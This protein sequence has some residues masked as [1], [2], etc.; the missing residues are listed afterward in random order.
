M[1]NA[2]LLLML[3]FF[4]TSCE[5]EVEVNAPYDDIPVVYGLLDA[6][7]SVHYI[8]INKTFLG[9]GNANDMAAIRDSSEFQTIRAS[10]KKVNQFDDSK[11]DREYLLEAV[12]I[13]NRD[14]GLFYAPNQTVYRFLEPNLSVDHKYRLDI[15][16][17]NG[18][19]TASAVTD[20]IS[21][22]DVF[23]NFR[24]R[25]ET[26]FWSSIKDNGMRFASSDTILQ[27]YKLS[28]FPP[29]NSKQVQLTFV[30]LYNDVVRSGGGERIIEQSFQI[31]LGSKVVN[32][33]DNP[34]KAE[35]ELSALNFFEFVNSRIPSAE[36]TPNLVKR[37]PLGCDFIVTAAEEE[38]HYYMEV[39]TPSGD[40]NQE[41]PEYTNIEGGIGIFSSRL[42]TLFT[43]S[44]DIPYITLNDETIQELVDGILTERFGMNIGE[45][46]WCHSNLPSSNP[47]S[48]NYVP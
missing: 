38:L 1:K 10:V 28:V 8:K 3:G 12:E 46:A 37:V 2:I 25:I 39:N 42:R 24:Y 30:F 11:F 32:N 19:K 33:P 17:D 5:T 16:I 40:L 44:Q 20:L 31:N 18:R 47:K 22:D 26:A 21:P 34:D 41:K 45:Q 13:T 23:R 6:S 36:E 4:L 7:D 48:C 29:K 27:G 15:D 9:L 14:E 35:F 43:Q